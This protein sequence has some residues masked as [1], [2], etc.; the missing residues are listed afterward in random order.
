MGKV[1]T[2]GELR[3]LWKEFSEVP[4]D[5]NDEILRGFQHFP[6]GSDRFEVWAWFDVQCP[7]GVYKDLFGTEFE[8]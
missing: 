6:K 1:R 5:D 4:I 7:N 2:L 3:E 8:R